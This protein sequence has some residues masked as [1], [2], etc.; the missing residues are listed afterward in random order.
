M[1]PDDQKVEMILPEALV[2]I[3]VSTGFYQRMQQV[4]E[5]IME[6][7]EEKEVIAAYSMLKADNITEPWVE[8]MKTMLVFLKDFQEGCKNNGFVKA[9]TQ[10]EAE[11]Y[12]KKTYPEEAHQFEKSPEDIDT[13]LDNTNPEPTDEKQD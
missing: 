10:S 3:K 12:L 4:F 13:E 8:H 2:D 7:K 1:L 9:M 5:Y 6:S 11:A